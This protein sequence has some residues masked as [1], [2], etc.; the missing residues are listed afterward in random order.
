MRIL[1]YH[2]RTLSTIFF[3]LTDSQIPQKVS[4]ALHDIKDN[5]KVCQGIDRH[6][7]AADDCI[8][9]YFNDSL[10]ARSVNCAFLITSTQEECCEEC[11]RLV[12]IKQEVDIDR[13]ETVP[14]EKKLKQET[15]DLLLID[16]LKNEETVEEHTYEEYN[17]DGDWQPYDDYDYEPAEIIPIKRKRGRPPKDPALKVHKEPKK[18]GRPRL[19]YPPNER[20]L[21]KKPTVKREEKSEDNQSKKFTCQICLKVYK[22]E[23]AV[24][25]HFLSH[26]KFFDTDGDIDCPVCK[27]SVEKLSLT[28]HFAEEHSNQ[29]QSLTCCLA[30]LEVIPHHQGEQ[31]R[32]HI[33][34]CHQQ[35]HVCEICGKVFN[36]IKNLECHVKTK[37]F[38]DSKEFFCDRC[39]KGFG[40]EIALHKH[41]Q[42]ACAMEE[43][44]CELCS[45]IF[46]CRKK[47]RF[48]LMVHCEDKPY[49]CKLCAYRS[50]KADNLCLH[51]KKTH[52]LKGVRA[53]FLT[54]TDILKT[55]TEFIEKYIAKARIK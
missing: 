46:G 21:A 31:L 36:Y 2:G 34:Q 7:N 44:K 39:G 22:T 17:N 24:N 20:H 4:E 45:K 26:E 9:E 48:H 14:E 1:T 11:Q 50:Y 43:W 8:V 49:A 41:V 37:H 15:A 13:I 5:A 32:Q 12:G 6:K 35:K 25:H 40:H 42:V 38:P 19:V 51:V 16:S 10:V 3:K 47:L 23:N 18:R 54:L 33:F 52:H 30:C 28:N 53:D 55:Q 27:K 29:E